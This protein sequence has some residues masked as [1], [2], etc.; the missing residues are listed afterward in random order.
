MITKFSQIFA[1]GMNAKRS[2]MLMRNVR[3]SFIRSIMDGAHYTNLV[4]NEESLTNQLL[5]FKKSERVKEQI[6]KMQ[7]RSNLKIDLI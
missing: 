7:K 1:K 5:P 4:P 6:F 2:A 3:S